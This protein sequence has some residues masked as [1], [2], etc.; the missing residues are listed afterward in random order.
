MLSSRLLSLRP[1][2]WWVLRLRS[3]TE[4]ENG[5]CALVRGQQVGLLTGT[6]PIMC[7][8]P[9]RSSFWGV[10]SLESRGE[11]GLLLPGPPR[12]GP[13]GG[14]PRYSALGSGKMFICLIT[15]DMEACFLSYVYE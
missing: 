5:R 2:V 7:P 8:H 14:A 10:K 13:A 12:L 11:A 3:V 15:V 1:D 6:C 4:G 9:L